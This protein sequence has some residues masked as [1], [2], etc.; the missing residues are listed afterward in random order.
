MR[1]SYSESVEHVIYDH[2]YVSQVFVA[3]CPAVDDDVADGDLDDVEVLDVQ[4]GHVRDVNVPLDE[5]M[6]AM[7]NWKDAVYMFGLLSFLKLRVE[8][9]DYAH[10]E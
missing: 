3:V 8:Q 1:I 5:C 9:D 6:Y 10:A 7:K 4:L 2:V